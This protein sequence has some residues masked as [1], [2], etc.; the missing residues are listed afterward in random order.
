MIGSDPSPEE[1]EVAPEPPEPVWLDRNENRYGPSPRCLEIL[2][3]PDISLLSRYTPAGSLGS[4]GPLAS[5]LALLHGVPPEQIALGYGA[6]D[7]LKGAFRHWVRSGDLCLIPAASWWYYAFLAGEAGAAALKYP[8]VEGPRRYTYAL[9]ELIEIGRSERVRL[10]LLASPNNP[11]GHTF[12]LERLEE[13]LES[14]R[15]AVVLYDEAYW[16]FSEEALSDA[17][18]LTRAHP[19][20]V[21]LRSFSKLYGLAGARIGYAVTGAAAA[22]FA[23]SCNLYLGFNRISEQLALAALSDRGYYDGVRERLVRD[24]RRVIRALREHA[25]VRAYESEAN[26][27]LAHIAESLLAPLEASLRREGLV[28]KFFE[29]PEFAGCVRITL[30]T[31]EENSRLLAVLREVLASA[32]VGCAR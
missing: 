23:A 21:V 11:T 29:E 12:P 31:E 15:G 25:E 16:G 10:L 7:L 17:A 8:M 20:L 6:E 32:S 28:I 13:V 4:P 9:D 14:F 22:S 30:G 3:R 5:R 27:V 2:R 18:A 19:N 26:F 1:G 24:R